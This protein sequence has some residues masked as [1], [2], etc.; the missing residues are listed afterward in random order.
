MCGYVLQR[1]AHGTALHM[2]LKTIAPLL[3]HSNFLPQKEMPVPAPGE[4]EE[5]EEFDE[6]LKAVHPLVNVNSV[7]QTHLWMSYIDWLGLIVVHFNAVEILIRYFTGEG[8]LFFSYF[9][10]PTCEQTFTPMVRTPHRP[11]TLSHK[12]N[13]EPF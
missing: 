11:N 12:N 6:D 7:V 9:D 4:V 3:M 10:P 2:H 5:Q 13:M 8:G 1:L